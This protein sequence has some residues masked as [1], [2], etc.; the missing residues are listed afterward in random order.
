MDGADESG[1]TGHEPPRPNFGEIA[2]TPEPFSVG[3][4]DQP[5]PSEVVTSPRTT[6]SSLEGST[7]SGPG[8]AEPKKRHRALVVSV[9]ALIMIAAGVA[10][11]LAT[12]GGSSA[13]GSGM[14]PANFVVTSTQNTVAQRTANIDI[15]GSISVDGATIPVSGSGQADFTTDQSSAS[16]DLSS[17]S[18]T[19]QEKEL[20]SGGQVY[21]DLSVDGQDLS[22]VTGGAQW[23]QI[24][25][26][27]QS[28]SSIGAADVDPIGAIKMLEQRGATVVPL[29][30]SMIGTDEVS[31]YSVTPSQA[32]IQG[33]LEQEV[34]SGQLPASSFSAEV[35]DAKTL[36]TFDVDIW[37]DG[38][39][40]LR[41]E[42]V[43]LSGGTS[44]ATA[45]VDMTFQDYGTPVSIAAPAPGSVV[46]FSQ[47]M[48][49]LNNAQPAQ[50]S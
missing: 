22:G 7:L 33:A 25:T 17:P 45:K 2:G 42:S 18:H 8:S 11:V 43:N 21:L 5:L 26:P 34:Q 28:A 10:G 27:Q 15:S 20:E 24:P 14:S 4:L 16:M 35:T 49:N 19:V 12:S 41:R 37:I 13:P 3:P 50:S 29:G 36:G 32:E 23:I 30:S 6:G 38:N 31:G 1:A 46:S 40:L 44:G 47:F 48:S 9:I 39:N